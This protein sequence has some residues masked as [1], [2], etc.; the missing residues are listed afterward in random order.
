MT[1][2]TTK[3]ISDAYI[4]AA[5]KTDVRY[6][7]DSRRVEFHINAARTGGTFYDVVYKGKKRQR[8]KLAKWPAVTAKRLFAELPAIRANAL[9]DRDASLTVSTYQTGGEVLMWFMQHID[10]DNTFSDS[11]VS[12]ASSY[13]GNH[14]LSLLDNVRLNDIDK[15]FL[16]KQL[17][18]PMQSE[19]ALSTIKG[20]LGVLKTACSR[21]NELGLIASNPTKSIT[22]T[23]FTTTQPDSQPGR[24]KPHDLPALLAAINKQSTA[25]RIFFM[26][27]LLHGTRI[28]ETCLAEWKHFSFNMLEWYIPAENT[29]NGTEH[30]LPITQHAMDLINTLPK[31]GD[32]LFSVKGDKPM[33]KRTVERWYQSLSDDVGIKFTSH[34]IRKLARDSWQDIGIDWVIG[35]MLL[36]HERD[37][38]DKRYM[39]THSREQMRKALG[40]WG[41]VIKKTT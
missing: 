32:Y 7:Y 17:Y 27:Q 18:M 35:E 31:R 1:R 24:L 33:A 15:T 39:H 40:E 29:K 30:R 38:L 37:G 5:L 4:R 3:N 10:A 41:K 36:N 26:T 23:S 6:L 16:Y 8:T 25:R 19:Y 14:L 13:I 34:D 9:A 2:R 22:L 12:T 28:G 21:A 20:V 11:Y